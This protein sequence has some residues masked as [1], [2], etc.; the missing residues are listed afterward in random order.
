MHIHGSFSVSATFQTGSGDC[1]ASVRIL[2][3][4][5]C[6]GNPAGR[7]VARTIIREHPPAAIPHPRLCLPSLFHPFV[8]SVIPLI[9]SGITRPSQRQQ[10]SECSIASEC[11]KKH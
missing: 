4:N 5:I 7:E 11:S 8:L 6:T 10:M 3:T 2:N 1:A 9:L